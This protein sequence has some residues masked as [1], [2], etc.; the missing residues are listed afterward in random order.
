ME[1]QIIDELVENWLKGKYDQKPMLPGFQEPT[2]EEN[3]ED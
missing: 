2:N 3:E 1:K